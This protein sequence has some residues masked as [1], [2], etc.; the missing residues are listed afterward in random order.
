MLL[1]SGLATQAE[2]DANDEKATQVAEDAAEFAEN[3]AD[4]AL[5]ELYN[6]ILVDNSAAIVHRHK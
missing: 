3:S 5:E 1:E 4:P 2:F 6:D